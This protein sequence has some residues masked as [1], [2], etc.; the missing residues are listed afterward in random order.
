MADGVEACRTATADVERRVRKYAEE[1]P[2]EAPMESDPPR[3]PP[4]KQQ[5]AITKLEGLLAQLQAV[6]VSPYCRLSSCAIAITS[7]TRL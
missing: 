1:D 4:T 3:R 5:L 7:G 6:L 2:T